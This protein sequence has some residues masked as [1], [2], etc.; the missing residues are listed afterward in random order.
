M[1][2]HFI[3]RHNA[4]AAQGPT[5]HIFY[6]KAFIVKAVIASIATKH[7]TA[8]SCTAVLINWSAR[9]K[10]DAIFCYLNNEGD[11]HTLHSACYW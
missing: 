7:I 6:L 11:A 9:C 4:N 10:Q 1:R 3:H 2:G 8:T 5:L